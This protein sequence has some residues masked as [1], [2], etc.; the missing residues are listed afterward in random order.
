MGRSKV[1]F[2]C[3][4]MYIFASTVMKQS[5]VIIIPVYK[6]LSSSEIQSLKSLNKLEQTNTVVCVIGSSNSLQSYFHTIESILS[7]KFEVMHISFHHSYFE[8][9]PGYNRLL[10][11]KEFYH[12]FKAFDYMLIFQTDAFIIDGS[13][14]TF[15]EKNVIYIGSPFLIADVPEKEG[16]NVG[17]GGFSL[18]HISTFSQ[19]LKE[20]LVIPDRFWRSYSPK[21]TLKRRLFKVFVYLPAWFWS[22][23]ICKSFYFES[24][25]YNWMNEDIVWS[26]WICNHDDYRLPTIK[27]ALMFSFETSPRECYTQN[28]QQLPF[29]CHARE[30]YDYV[31]WKTHLSELQA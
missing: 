19:I 31:F 2:N 21:H 15:L 17:N 13:L 27:D 1:E 9:I 3:Y 25:K 18:R 30:R 23:L 6:I 8:D 4:R 5:V 12:Q 10:L 11:S 24:S 22:R 29:G 28:H 20:Q 7:N 16:L 26:R 14:S